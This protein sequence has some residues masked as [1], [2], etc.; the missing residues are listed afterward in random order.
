MMRCLALVAMLACR[1]P[2][3]HHAI[4]PATGDVIE[5]YDTTYTFDR[6]RVT[7]S[8]AG[9]VV[10]RIDA[11]A[12]WAHAAAIPGPDGLQWVVAIS[13]GKLWRV[14][15]LGELEPADVRLGLEGAAALSIAGGDGTYAIGLSDGVAASRDGIHVLRF[16]GAPA[17]L[18]AAGRDVV[19]VGRPS[20]IDVLDLA[21][22]TSTSFAFAG[23]DRV[24][25][26]DGKLAVFAGDDTYVQDG[27]VLRRGAIPASATRSEWRSTLEPIFQ[28]A[29]AKCHR[30]GGAA[31]F[32]LSTSAAW[33]AARDKI[34]DEVSGGTMPP[35]GESPL[36]A[37]DRAAL[38][39][40]YS[41]PR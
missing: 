16:A 35:E 23:A 18:V 6:A 37:T 39:R 21:R 25:L 4:A 34:R 17:P 13:D 22:G 3:V 33:F 2:S 5:L 11:P 36:S 12:S 38:E 28:R 32:D 10:A 24:E 20:A 7:I 15:S 31:D 1:S 14:T 29:C 26:V 9:A 30:P 8:R 27:A 41:A 40:W 19:A